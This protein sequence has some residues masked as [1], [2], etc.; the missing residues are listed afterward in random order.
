MK[1]LEN[2]KTVLV[3]LLDIHLENVQLLD[4][5]EMMIQHLFY[6]KN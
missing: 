2:G 5:H 1:S 3:V 6:F 4:F